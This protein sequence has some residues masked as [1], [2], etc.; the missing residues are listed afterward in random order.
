MGEVNTHIILF[1]GHLRPIKNLLGQVAFGY[2]SIL[3]SAQNIAFSG[4]SILGLNAQ[5]HQFV[6]AYKI[7]QLF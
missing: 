2:V 1:T 3:S 6:L 7:Y 4:A 5:G